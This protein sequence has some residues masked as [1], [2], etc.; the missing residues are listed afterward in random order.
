M[1]LMAIASLTRWQHTD[2]HQLSALEII[3]PI[4]KHTSLSSVFPSLLV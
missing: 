3:F 4:I 1:I 2:S